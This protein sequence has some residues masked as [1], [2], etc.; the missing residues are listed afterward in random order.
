MGVTIVALGWVD[1]VRCRSYILL[2]GDTVL[3]LTG[4]PGCIHC[5]SMP[6]LDNW[7]LRKP[8][9]VHVEGAYPVLGCY[10][11]STCGRLSG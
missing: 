10:L 5:I 3:R 1:P 6:P 9:P 4:C 2:G 11:M 7:Y 8:L